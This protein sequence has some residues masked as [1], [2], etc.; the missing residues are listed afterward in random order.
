MLPRR[1]FLPPNLP[2]AAEARPRPLRTAPKALVVVDKP[3]L[4]IAIAD[5]ALRQK[6]IGICNMREGKIT[7]GCHHHHH[8]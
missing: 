8:I 6:R 2:P 1:T 5:S 3:V 4:A 7:A